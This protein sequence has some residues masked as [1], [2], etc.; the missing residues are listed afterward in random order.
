MTFIPN[1]VGLLAE[2]ET[3]G[4]VTD[5]TFSNLN[6]VNDRLYRIYMEVE[7]PTV[8]TSNYHIYFN[9]DVVA[10]N[11]WSNILYAANGSTNFVSVNEPR[12]VSNVL[13]AANGGVFY[14][15][16]DIIFNE[17]YGFCKWISMNV[18]N[19]GNNIGFANYAG[20]TVISIPM[21]T[22]GG[23]TDIT[24][25]STIANAIATGSKFSL[26]RVSPI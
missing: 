14:G 13:N 21:T 23:I 16:T 8:S 20:T 1:S 7:N 22:I 12:I 15:Y 2:Q 6:I 19:M 10:T 3:V 18:I 9:G 26:Y 4:A 25:H 5:V 17:Y 11:Y 24:I